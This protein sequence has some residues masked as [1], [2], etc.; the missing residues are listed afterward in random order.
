MKF[1]RISKDT[2][3]NLAAIATIRFYEHD[4]VQDPVLATSAPPAKSGVELVAD[5][6]TVNGSRHTVTGSTADELAR[7]IRT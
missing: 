3:L 5:I 7:V 6:I 4:S 1:I 2:L